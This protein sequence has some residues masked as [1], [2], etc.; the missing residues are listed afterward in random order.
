ME[1]SYLV[2]SV[3]V[4]IMMLVESR[5]LKKTGGIFLGNTVLSVISLLEFLWLIVSGLAIF[6][7][8]LPTW[9][10]TVP[11]VYAMYNLSAWVY[12]M[13]LFKREGILDKIAEDEDTDDIAIPKKYRDF[14]FSF[15][16]VFF[17]LSIVAAAYGINPE[18]F[19]QLLQ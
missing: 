19:A 3:L 16:V 7:L 18:I 2:I 4:A 15:A 9:T 5:I 17:M 6:Q 12:G 1:V 11:L 10:I 13:Y 14:S 8:D